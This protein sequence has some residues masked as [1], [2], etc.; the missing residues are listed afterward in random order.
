MQPNCEWDF[1]KASDASQVRAISS[2]EAEAAYY[3]KRISNFLSDDEE[4]EHQEN[5]SQQV[6]AISS[7]DKAEHSFSDLIRNEV[8]RLEPSPKLRQLLAKV[9]AIRTRF[10]KMFG[11]EEFECTPTF[12]KEY[13]QDIILSTPTLNLNVKSLERVGVNQF[14]HTVDVCLN[15]CERYAAEQEHQ[16]NNLP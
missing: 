5:K 6:R 14:W 4:Q 11:F 8:A 16:E 12:I 2:D 10:A 13:L 1:L 9:R 15:A 3:R 7:L